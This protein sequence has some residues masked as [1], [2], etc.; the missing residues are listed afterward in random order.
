MPHISVA[1]NHFPVNESVSVHTEASANYEYGE[2]RNCGTTVFEAWTVGK[3]G[4]KINP[5]VVTTFKGGI[6]ERGGIRTKDGFICYNCI[7]RVI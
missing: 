3:G 6:T 2:C 1:N 4:S 5:F 7:T